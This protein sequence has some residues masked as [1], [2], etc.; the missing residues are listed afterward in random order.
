VQVTVLPPYLRGTGWDLELETKGSKKNQSQDNGSK[1]VG[2]LLA[3]SRLFD[4]AFFDQGTKNNA[5]KEQ[6][7]DNGF[8]K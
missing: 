8:V 1:V 4:K 6:H 7:A 5:N 2:I 3:P